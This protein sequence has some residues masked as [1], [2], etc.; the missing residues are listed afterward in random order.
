LFFFSCVYLNFFVQY[1][2]STAYY[3]DPALAL[4]HS[5]TAMHVLQSE[6]FWK[7]S[8]ITD[9]FVLGRL[10]STCTQLRPLSARRDV[11]ECLF[12]NMAE[13]GFYDSECKRKKIRRLFRTSQIT[14]RCMLW[15]YEISE[16]VCE[17]SIRAARLKMWNSLDGLRDMYPLTQAEESDRDRWVL[18]F[19][20]FARLVL[21]RMEPLLKA[22]TVF[23]VTHA[24]ALSMLKVDRC[25]EI[26]PAV[27]CNVLLGANDVDFA[28]RLHCLRFGALG[29]GA[30]AGPPA[31]PVDEPDA[32]GP[33]TH[34]EEG[35]DAE[36]EDVPCHGGVH[37]A[38]PAGAE[39]GD[40]TEGC[41]A[42]EVEQGRE[43]DS[44]ERGGVDGVN[45]TFTS[46]G[47]RVGF[48]LVAPKP[49]RRRLDF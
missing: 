24:W 2:F 12:L 4:S 20:R 40:C 28:H 31:A 46:C 42:A 43:D 16:E 22:S 27:L 23:S 41:E 36:H 34:N 48:A 32:S 8:M 14:A 19:P 35:H 3:F 49:V 9:P 45:D 11:W 25:G 21:R 5:C 30:R 18:W 6:F 13:L 15:Q 29:L 39:E 38:G 26:S 7:R 1:K 17:S 33:D 10:S 44:R 47:K 37:E